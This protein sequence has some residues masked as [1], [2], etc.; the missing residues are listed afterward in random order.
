MTHD[1]KKGRK[2]DCW[3]LDRMEALLAC[4]Q[5][6][7]LPTRIKRFD[8]VRSCSPS[9]ANGWKCP[10]TWSYVNQTDSDAPTYDYFVADIEDFTLM[11]DHNF[12]SDKTGVQSDDSDMN[13]FWLE[14]PSDDAPSTACTRHSL[15]CKAPHCSSSRK[16]SRTKIDTSTYSVNGRE[17]VTLP[18]GEVGLT[19]QKG[20]VFSLGTLLSLA[21]VRLA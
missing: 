9:E 3:K 7:L 14:C 19:I 12:R 8:Q 2:N 15:L 16:G 11:F 5:G 18:M 10:R 6:Y 20:D 4:E 21:N 13:G 17:I 1:G